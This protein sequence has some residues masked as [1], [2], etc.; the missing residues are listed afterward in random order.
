MFCLKLNRLKAAH[1]KEVYLNIFFVVYY[2]RL[3]LE[4]TAYLQCMFRVMLLM[5]H[6][7]RKISII[8][9]LSVSL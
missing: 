6:I 1:N 9:D 8:H 7:R 5:P 4:R 3:I 2:F